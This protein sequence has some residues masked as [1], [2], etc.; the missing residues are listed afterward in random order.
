MILRRTKIVAT[1]GPACDN[2]AV[3]SRVIAAGADVLRLNYSHDDRTRQGQRLR[4]VRRLAKKLDLEVGIMADLQGPKIRIGGFTHG[5]VEIEEGDDFVIDVDLELNAGDE[6]HVG[7]TYKDLPKDVRAGDTLLLDDGQIIL[8]VERS[9]GSLVE[10][11]VLLGGTLSDFKGINRD[12][13]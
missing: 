6:H 11:V 9:K 2:P 8:Q 10:C 3:L 12:F 1:L 5:S 7:V 4:R 13:L